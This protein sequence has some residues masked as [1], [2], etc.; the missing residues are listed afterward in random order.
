M[1][2]YYAPGACSLAVH[3]ALR[4]AGIAFEAVRVDLE[5][6]VTETGGDYLQISPKGAVPSLVMDDGQLLTEGVVILQYL[7]DRA[8]DK[9]LAPLA[10]S[11]ARYRL[12]EWLN[13][14]A[15]DLFKNCFPFFYGASDDIK[16]IYR[17]SLTRYYTI[18]EAQLSKTPWLLGDTFT[19]ADIYL[20]VI[21]RYIAYTGLD[22]ATWPSLQAFQKTVEA[23]PAVKEA[24]TFEGLLK[25]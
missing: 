11:L 4:E 20:Y 16:T 19:V 13:M 24:L 23:R 8:P 6:K 10:G 1:K 2:L 25:S 14:I 15:T 12:M 3:I 9:K 5:K 18:V 7:A 21:S 17:N 22:V